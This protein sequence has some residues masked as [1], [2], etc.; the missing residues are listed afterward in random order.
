MAITTTSLGGGDAATLSL[1]ITGVEAY[2]QAAQAMNQVGTA[3]D[4]A[5]RGAESL[6]NGMAS[7]D[8]AARTFNRALGAAGLLGSMLLLSKAVEDVVLAVGRQGF[9]GALEDATSKIPLLGLINRRASESWAEHQKSIQKSKEALTDFV[10]KAQFGDD[11]AIR[12][13]I[14]TTRG[15]IEGLTAALHNL[16]GDDWVKTLNEIH[17]TSEL[18]RQATK[19]MEDEK[20]DQLTREK[21]AVLQLRLEY[22]KLWT[23]EQLLA[24]T[25]RGPADASGVVADFMMTAKRNAGQSWTPVPSGTYE[26]GVS[27]NWVGAGGPG[28]SQYQSNTSSGFNWARTAFVAGT[29]LSSGMFG[30]TVGS[31]SS[32]AMSGALMGAQLGSVIPGVGTAVG[33]VVG[34]VGG[35]VSGLIGHSKRVRE[36]EERLKEAQRGFNLSLDARLAAARGDTERAEQL[37]RMARYEKE[38]AD[39]RKAG[40]SAASIKV[41][42]MVQAEE[43]L[44]AERE[45]AKKA[46]EEA[47]EAE[48]RRTEATKDLIVR[49]LTASGQDYWA[50]KVGL[51]VSQRRERYDAEQDK[52]G[53]EFLAFMDFVHGIEMKSLELNESVRLQTETIQNTANA[54]LSVLDQQLQTAQMTAQIQQEQLR[55]QEATV[56]ALRNVVDSLTGYSNELKV[57]SLSTLSPIQQLTSARTQFEGLYSLAAGGDLSAA[58][59]IR[60]AGNTLLSLSRGYSASGSGFVSDFNRVQSAVDALL[61]KYGTQL[62]VEERILAELQNQTAQTNVLIQQLGTQ[63]ETV[64]AEAQRQIDAINAQAAADRASWSAAL[65]EW[66]NA[67]DWLHDIFGSL[68]LLPG[69]LNEIKGYPPILNTGVEPYEVGIRDATVN[70]A[71]YTQQ[72]FA[73]T[74][75][76][77]QGLRSELAGL[78]EDMLY[79]YGP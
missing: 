1:R 2:Q 79:R 17:R 29:A 55:N 58:Q 28:S 30:E 3:G 50:S 62:P 39:A 14:A 27:P 11:F 18:V 59:S 37:E 51:M 47:A 66:A 53:P 38:L 22:N 60:G 49:G 20:I 13:A 7:A 57:G 21:I 5:Q 42:E 23:S 32:S 69:K 64:R 71:M 76:E 72:G 19:V 44:A 48:R 34:A 45:R 4:R 24:G 6:A 78:R 10:N 25:N 9:V 70:T 65:L 33:A 74:V 63:I 54:T 40:M 56:S 41:L 68:D 35:L 31:V 61:N 15:E 43:K 52:M 26:P 67:N 12:K 46:A 77:L 36:E 73:S 75:D 16:D 8:R